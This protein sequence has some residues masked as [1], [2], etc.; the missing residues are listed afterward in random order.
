M[1]RKKLSTEEE[2]LEELTIPKMI[3]CLKK[4]LVNGDKTKDLVL[5]GWPYTPE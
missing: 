3:E 5:D 2:E 1:W 4:E